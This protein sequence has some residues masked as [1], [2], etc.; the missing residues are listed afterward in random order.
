ML[1]PG[2]SKMINS[3]RIIELVVIF[4]NIIAIFYFVKKFNHTSVSCGLDRV[5]LSSSLKGAL[6]TLFNGR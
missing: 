6:L 2:Y 4:S 1:I 3:R 5:S